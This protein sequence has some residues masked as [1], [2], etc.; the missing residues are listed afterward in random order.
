[1]WTFVDGDLSR[2]NGRTAFDAMRQGDTE[3]TR[4]VEKYTEYLA[5]GIVNIV[6]IFQPE[7]ICIGGGISKEGET[8]LKPINRYIGQYAFSRFADKN[9]VVRI[10]E[11]GN[12]AGVI[13]A[14]F[15]KDAFHCR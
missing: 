5:E 14:A 3:G 4:V 15:L 13:G 12:D 2:V 1:M 7:I 10:A 11:L 8:L 6:N 9:T